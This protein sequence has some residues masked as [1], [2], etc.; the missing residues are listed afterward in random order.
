MFAYRLMLLSLTSMPFL[1]VQGLETSNQ[2]LRAALAQCATLCTQGA[3]AHHLIVWRGNALSATHDYSAHM[4]C[5]CLEIVVGIF[6]CPSVDICPGL[7]ALHK[8]DVIQTHNSLIQ[9]Q[10]LLSAH[11]PT[12]FLMSH[13]EDVDPAPAPKSS[14][15]GSGSDTTL[16]ASLEQLLSSHSD[17]VHDVLDSGDVTMYKALFTSAKD[18]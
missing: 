16:V 11:T 7:R 18:Q 6:A 1:G 10:E 13:S 9:M 14:V 8:D 3:D 2:Q 4:S 12:S 5:A 17:V 15:L